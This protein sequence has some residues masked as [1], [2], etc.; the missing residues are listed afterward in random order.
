MMRSWQCSS[1]GASA[2][3]AGQEVSCQ[4]ERSND[5]RA[6]RD[7]RVISVGGSERVPIPNSIT[8]RPDGTMPFVSDCKCEPARQLSRVICAARHFSPFRRLELGPLRA[9]PLKTCKNTGKSALDGKSG[10]PDVPVLASSGRKRKLK[11]TMVA[12]KPVTRANSYK[13]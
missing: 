6:A 12:R 8:R 3:P 5:L 10:G 11:Q 1:L 7:A 13:P 2:K 9:Q 4:S